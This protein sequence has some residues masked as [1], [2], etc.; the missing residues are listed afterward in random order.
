MKQRIVLQSNKVLVLSTK[1]VLTCR[2]SKRAH[3]PRPG[4]FFRYTTGL[5]CPKKTRNLQQATA[6]ERYQTHP[7][8]YLLFGR[9]LL[10]G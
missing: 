4:K 5:K 3:L 7:S 6:D 8:C 1:L 9:R 2:D 10:L